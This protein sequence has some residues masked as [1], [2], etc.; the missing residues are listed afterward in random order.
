MDPF[1]ARDRN[2][3]QES[4]SNEGEK[5]ITGDRRMD[6]AGSGRSGHR[7]SQGTGE[8]FQ[9]LEYRERRSQAFGASLVLHVV[10][11][12]VV[13][14]FPLFFTDS[15]K[16]KYEVVTL[17][18]PVQKTEPLVA[19]P[20]TPLP[21]PRPLR[22]PAQPPVKPPDV[23]LVQPPKPEVIRKPDVPLPKIE[24][25]EAP[26]PVLTNAP[27]IDAPK[28]AVAPPAPPKPEIKTGVFSKPEDTAATTNVPPRNVQTGGFGDPNGLPARNSGH[29]ANIAS[30]GAFDLPAGPGA[31]NG[32]GGKTGV[33]G[34][35]ADSGFGASAAPLNSRN[36]SPAGSGPTD[37]NV[38]QSGF[39]QVQAASPAVTPKK[40]DTGPPDK[41][42][43]ITFKP[44]PEYTDEARKLRVEGEV[45][46][47]VLFK[48]NGEIS[49]LDLIRGLGHGLDENAIRAAQQIRFKPALRAG[50]PVD[51]TATVHI[52]FQ[53]AF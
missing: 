33:G 28:V 12:F 23:P 6:E 41:V 31:G 26:P 3:L 22:Q 38:R 47:H 21:D 5:V 27:H 39:D 30:V 7:S 17:A 9:S 49:V 4:S 42:A 48:A 20:W 53:L 32:T 19:T 40:N 14:V 46:V 35:V 29:P 37:R 16:L 44:R 1:K 11:L 2:T 52:L 50:Q 51:S 15:L 10:I 8:I 45:L 13:I 24:Q 34:I 25:P 43:E 36:G 18:P